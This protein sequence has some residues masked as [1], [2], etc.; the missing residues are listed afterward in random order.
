[1]E[2][3]AGSTPNTAG[4]S[5][6]GFGN[7][8]VGVNRLRGVIRSMPDTLAWMARTSRNDSPSDCCRTFWNACHS[9]VSRASTMRLWTPRSSMN[10]MTC[11]CAPAPI[12]SIDSTAATPKIIPSIVRTVR[13][14]WTSRLSKLRRR[15]GSH[16]SAAGRHD[17]AAA[18][19]V[20]AKL[21]G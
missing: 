4:R 7:T 10:A 16:S 11:C 15:S 19:S 17:R 13:S 5:D 1:M 20:T 9:V 12:D 8:W 21:A 14:L 2:R 6:S 3:Y 18:G